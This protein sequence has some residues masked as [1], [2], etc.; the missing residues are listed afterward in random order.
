MA[1]IPK[2]IKRFWVDHDI[3][4]TPGHCF[5][6]YTTLSRCTAQ[7][8]GADI[9]VID[10]GSHDASPVLAVEGFV[11][12]SIGN[13]P[14][15]SLNSL[16]NEKFVKTQWAPDISFLKP[17]FLKQ[18]LS[19]PL[20]KIET[21]TLLDMR[22][23]CVYFIRDSLTF[24]TATDV[25][26]LDPHH[27]RFYSWMKLQVK[28]DMHAVNMQPNPATQDEKEALIAK[29]SAASVNGQMISRLGPKLTAILRREVTPLEIMLEDGFLNHYYEKL[30]KLDR[31]TQ[32]V[33][34]FVKHFVHKNP[35]AKILE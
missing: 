33:A 26:Q 6:A 25:Q 8:F 19:Y 34:E 27:K 22:R 7:S 16:E 32:Q 10:D 24:L 35:R 14:H 20:H 9:S 2:S 15:Q 13:G 17:A 11:C 23:L 28:L 30:L 29:A 21:E 3:I 18:Q 31:S 5:N 1:Q 12:Q 4:S